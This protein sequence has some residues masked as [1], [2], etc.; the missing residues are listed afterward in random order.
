MEKKEIQ[1]LLAE[2]PL[3]K[4]VRRIMQEAAPAS[5]HAQIATLEKELEGPVTGGMRAPLA[6]A[7][8]K[9]KEA[10]RLASLPLQ[11]AI[12]KAVNRIL[13]QEG[14]AIGKPKSTATGTGGV[15]GKRKKINVEELRRKVLAA[16][17]QDPSQGLPGNL[18]AKECGVSYSSL[19]KNL[20]SFQEQGYVVREGTGNGTTW[21]R[22][23]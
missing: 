23:A 15:G 14:L 13:K 11:G 19:R 9:M 18:L 1:R 8:A 6:E 17:P 7:V 10:E 4:A 2:M 16:L 5:L 12:V 22:K 21:H 3:A 20:P